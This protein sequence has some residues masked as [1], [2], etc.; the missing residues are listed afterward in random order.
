MAEPDFA[1]YESFKNRYKSGGNSEDPLPPFIVTNPVTLQGLAI[2]KRR[3]AVLDWLPV[4][5][6]TG[7]YGEGGT[8]KTILLHM[9]QVSMA[10]GRPWLGIPVE[11]MRSLG[12]YCEDPP[13]ELHRRQADLNRHHGV[14]MQDLASMRWINRFSYDNILMEFEGTS[15][16][17]IFTPFYWQLVDQIRDFQPQIIMLDTV[18]DLFGGNEN[19][20]QQV[21]FFVQVGLGSLARMIDG[22]VIVSAH[23]SRAGLK[24]G[25]GDSGSTAWNAAFRSRL[26]LSAPKPDDDDEAPDSNKR[27]LER[28]KANYAPRHEELPLRW[29]DGVFVRTDSP[30]PILGHVDKIDLEGRLCDW[31]QAR[32]NN[33]ATIAADWSNPQYGFANIVRKD[34]P[35]KTFTQSQI[36][37]AQDRLIK[38]GRIV[39]VMVGIPSKR[40]LCLRAADQKYPREKPDDVVPIS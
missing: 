13:E 39:K 18:A 19:D 2:P 26:Y 25:E 11:A 36:V 31:L 12:V 32:V 22:A 33:G 40:R 6:I 28:K 20:R 14:E 37:A 29:Q 3:W 23:P 21:R 24:S 38:S 27:I 16:R 9:L 7:L 1:E 4:P 15:R 10:L 5:L 30:S 8:G 17:G 34:K 35:F